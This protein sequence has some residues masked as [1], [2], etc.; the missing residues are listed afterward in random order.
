MRCL[1]LSWHL[2][3]TPHYHCLIHRVLRTLLE[4]LT[5]RIL[6]A[7][8]LV[9][10][11]EKNP[12]HLL[13]PWGQLTCYLKKKSPLRA[14][15]QQLKFNRSML[16]SSAC[17]NCINFMSSEWTQSVSS[18]QMLRWCNPTRKEILADTTFSRCQDPALPT[19]RSVALDVQSVLFAST[20][21]FLPSSTQS[22]LE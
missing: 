4:I 14:A 12:S 15:D 8:C 19:K 2:N 13:S 10:W 22:W 7:S 9:R 5:E 17:P 11:G 21:L 1:C 18:S 3:G 20:D 6:W 16:L